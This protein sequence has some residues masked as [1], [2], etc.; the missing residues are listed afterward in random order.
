MHNKILVVDNTVVTGSFNFSGNAV[1]N[2]EN[3][4]QLDSNALADQYA[5]YV[6]QLIA[7]YVA[8]RA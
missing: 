3:V 4:L 5:T 8:T 1:R 7:R 6:D 2:A